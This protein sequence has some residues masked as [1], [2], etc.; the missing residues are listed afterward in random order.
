MT[1]KEVYVDIQEIKQPEMDAQLVAENVAVQLE[2]RVSFRRAMK[3]AVQV[4]MDF[5]PKASRCAWGE[6][7]AAPKSRA[8][9]NTIKAASSAY[10]AGQY[11][12]RICGGENGVWQA[13]DKMLDLQRRNAGGAKKER[14]GGARHGGQLKPETQT[15]ICIKREINLWQ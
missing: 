14:P 12:L 4:A 8:W 7:W 1:G 2:R 10:V 3:K 13:G 5:G 15:R 6:V 9:R 11:R